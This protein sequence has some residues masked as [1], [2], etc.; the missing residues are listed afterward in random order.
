[1]YTSVSG[2]VNVLS[3]GVGGNY[4]HGVIKQSGL[5][6]KK[7]YG[8]RLLRGS[9]SETF[10]QWQ[11]SRFLQRFLSS[12]IFGPCHAYLISHQGWVKISVLPYDLFDI[13][14]KLI[15]L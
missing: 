10:R 12:K 14:T 8:A 11:E 3:A 9:V 4:S 5:L 2:R 13:V 7:L 6:K 15:F 1:M